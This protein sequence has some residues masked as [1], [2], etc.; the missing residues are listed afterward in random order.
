MAETMQ[1]TAKCPHCGAGMKAF[2]HNLSPG[3]VNSL[4]KAIQHV[5]TSGKNRFNAN[6]DLGLTHN[7]AANFQKLRFHAL[8]AH[9]DGD[10]PRGGEWLITARG[11][12]FLRG[13]IAVPQRVKTFRN[14]VIDHDAHLID[15][16][17]YRGK[18]NEFERE[19]AYEYQRP[20]PNTMQFIPGGLFPHQDNA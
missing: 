13:E 6:K 15:I 4:I 12:A 7:E 8:V 16:A 2:W 1:T 11:G 14:K 3:L 17:A 5:H 9:A 18:V 10:N 20:R 19:F